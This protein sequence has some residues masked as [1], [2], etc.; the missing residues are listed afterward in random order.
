MLLAVELYA[1]ER[2]Q[3]W[4]S[5]YRTVPAGVLDTDLRLDDASFQMLLM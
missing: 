1:P 5:I 2:S 3:N 4:K